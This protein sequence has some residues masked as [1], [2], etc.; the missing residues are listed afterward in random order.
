M[1]RADAVQLFLF[2]RR[3]WCDA[4]AFERARRGSHH[5]ARAV[6]GG[7]RTDAA[8][9]RGAE[10]GERGSQHADLGPAHLHS[11]LSTQISTKS[12]AVILKR[13]PKNINARL[14]SPSRSIWTLHPRLRL[15]HRGGA[16]RSCSDMTHVV[17]TAR[18]ISS[19]ALARG[20][21]HGCRL[22]TAPLLAT[23]CFSALN[24]C[25][26]TLTSGRPFTPRPA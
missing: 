21:S 24:L 6:A 25:A 15:G 23:F 14:S 11:A 3:Q 12:G 18:G 20:I 7:K 17:A 1:A 22:C 5:R 4:E 8:G 2:H 10:Q 19:R 9:Q 13:A 26:P 16:G